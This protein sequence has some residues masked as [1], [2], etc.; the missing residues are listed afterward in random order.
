MKITLFYISVGY[1][2]K[3]SKKE[4]KRKRLF[5]NAVHEPIFIY[6]V[7]KRS[8]GCQC[9]FATFQECENALTSSAASQCLTQLSQFLGP[10][11]L[12]GRVEEYNPR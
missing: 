9:S 11:I 8:A 12:R 6:E 4:K 10:N 7:T 3:E 2:K 5:D 1:N